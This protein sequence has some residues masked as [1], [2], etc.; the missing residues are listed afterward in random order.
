MEANDKHRDA[1]DKHRDANDKHRDAVDKRRV[2]VDKRRA[3]FARNVIGLFTID[4]ENQ[5]DFC[6]FV[7]KIT[8]FFR[9]VVYGLETKVEI[10]FSTKY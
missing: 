10:T 2:A 8:P 6:L 9:L 1:N 5:I 7:D 4:Y 3:R